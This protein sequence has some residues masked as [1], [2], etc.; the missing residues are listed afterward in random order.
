MFAHHCEY[1]KARRTVY[2]KWVDLMVCEL[3]LIVKM[4]YKKKKCIKS[5]DG[6]RIH[7]K[8]TRAGESTQSH[9]Q[10]LHPHAI[11]PQQ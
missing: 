9:T 4:D 5:L 1:T 6:Y 10:R 7:F 3:Y 11:T 8:D 2:F